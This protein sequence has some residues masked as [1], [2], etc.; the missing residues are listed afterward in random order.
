MNKIITLIVFLL[1][2]ITSYGQNN[3]YFGS[4]LIP[5]NEYLIRPAN[6]NLYWNVSKQNSADID[7]IKN[8]NTENSK[9]MFIPA[10]K[11][12]YYI[13]FLKNGHYLTIK[14]AIKKGALLHNSKPEQNETQKFK[15]ISKDNGQFKFIAINKL[16]IEFS[17]NNFKLNSNTNN[18]NQIFEILEADSKKKFN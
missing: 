13:K 16:S 9:I 10:G 4:A 6:T 5:K 17:G 18:K 7:L 1:T 14:G 3:D 2:F 8:N 11:G 15:V 12:Y